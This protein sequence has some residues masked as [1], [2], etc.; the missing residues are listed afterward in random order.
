MSSIFTALTSPR[1][2][3]QTPAAAKS[4]SLHDCLETYAEEETL[5]DRYHCA[6][7]KTLQ[8]AKK[9][10]RIYKFPE[11]MVLHIKRF[12]FGRGFTRDKLTTRI[13]YPERL[14]DLAC[15]AS[16]EEGIL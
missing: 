16:R 6:R 7:C 4:C 8:R 13:D 11:I 14:D 10:L 12:T 15:I 1:G 9:G 2:A 3:A 5:D